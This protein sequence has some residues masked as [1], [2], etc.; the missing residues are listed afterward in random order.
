MLIGYVRRFL[1]TNPTPT[2]LLL[3]R[4]QLQLKARD[5]ARTPMPWSSLS[6]GGFTSPTSTPWMSS[7]PDY[8]TCNVASQLEDPNSVYNFWVALISLRRDY[9]EVLISGEFRLVDEKHESVFA[10]EK[11]HRRG[12]GLGEEKVL[13]VLNWRGLGTRW[14]VPEGVRRWVG[15]G[16]V[17]KSNYGRE[18]VELDIWGEGVLDL[19]PWEALLLL[20]R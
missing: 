5:N 10:Y 2:D 4:T 20:Q 19:G 12:P 11:V 18:G 8:L 9:K 14:N 16:E 13:V 7:N 6:H 1:Q 15:G 17:L 3:F